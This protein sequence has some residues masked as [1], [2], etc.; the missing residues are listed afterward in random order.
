MPTDYKRKTDRGM[1][2]REIYDLA[3]EEVTLRQKSLRDADSSY[4]L[5]HTALYS[6]RG[7]D[8]L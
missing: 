6:F 3:V 7:E 2:N 5:N 8:T 4:N 1:A